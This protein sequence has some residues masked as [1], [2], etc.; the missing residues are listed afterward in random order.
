MST[1]HSKSTV[2][3]PRDV[4]P[5]Y[6]TWS[7]DRV[8]ANQSHMYGKHIRL[9]QAPIL[10]AKRLKMTASTLGTTQHPLGKLSWFSLFL[11]LL[12]RMVVV[13]WRQNWLFLLF[14]PVQL[15]CK[16]TPHTCQH[17]MMGQCAVHQHPEAGG[18]SPGPQHGSVQPVLA[19][20]RSCCNKAGQ[21]QLPAG[22]A[23]LQRHGCCIRQPG[24]YHD[25]PS[26]MH[27]LE[28]VPYVAEQ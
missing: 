22:L 21:M 11:Q 5:S 4:I 12:S 18:K 1:D 24:K 8:A 15:V 14:L 17:C 28:H 6:C 2:A 19:P 16:V 13:D 9:K 26:C 23:D 20:H 27:L 25:I 7:F 10:C 3:Q